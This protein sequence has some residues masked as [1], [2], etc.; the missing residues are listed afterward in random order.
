MGGLVFRV[1][2]KTLARSSGGG[3]RHEQFVGIRRG[4]RITT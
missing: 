3:T 1:V 4:L 2:E